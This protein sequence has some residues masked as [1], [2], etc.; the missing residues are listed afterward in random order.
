MS[1]S[2]DLWETW[3]SNHQV[4]PIGA[5]S[6]D[7]AQNQDGNN[8]DGNASSQKKRGGQKGH[9][10]HFRNEFAEDQI[11]EVTEHTLTHCPSSWTSCMSRWTVCRR[12]GLNNCLA[13]SVWC[14][15]DNRAMISDA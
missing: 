7:N 14:R 10:G 2:T 9:E 4:H 3:R 12:S 8:Q 13:V 11:D 6:K 15:C 5:N 1:A